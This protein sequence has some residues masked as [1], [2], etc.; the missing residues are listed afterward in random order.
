LEEA[1]P[2]ARFCSLPHDSSGSLSSDQVA[3]V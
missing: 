2:G 1:A 3:A